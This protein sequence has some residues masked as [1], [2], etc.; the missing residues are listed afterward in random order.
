MNFKILL[1]TGGIINSQTKLT[2]GGVPF[3]ISTEKDAL[4]F[5]KKQWCNW[6]GVKSFS[7]WA[8]ELN[9]ERNDSGEDKLSAIS[10]MSSNF[11]LN[12]DD[13]HVNIYDLWMSIFS[14]QTA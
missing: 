1:A 4:R 12:I 3:V 2:A 14:E 11:T 5:I 10:H 7:Q 8:N 9:D 6:C 13:K